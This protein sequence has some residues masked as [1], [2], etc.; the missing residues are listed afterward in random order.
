V[1]K[2][3]SHTRFLVLSHTLP[4]PLTHT[5]LSSQHRLPRCRHSAPKGRLRHRHSGALRHPARSCGTPPAGPTVGTPPP[6][7]QGLALGTR[8]AFRPRTRALRPQP[9][10][11]PRQ[12]PLVG[13]PPR[14]AFKACTRHSPALARALRPPL[15]ALRRQTPLVGTP[16]RPGGLCP[17]ARALARH[18]VRGGHSAPSCRHSARRP[19]LKALRPVG[20]PVASGTPRH[21]APREALR[22]SCG[23]SALRPRVKALRPR[24]A[25]RPQLQAL[26]APAGPQL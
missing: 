17:G 10:A 16:P 4:C 13:T 2:V 18:S 23:H 7:L 1:G 25:L 5:A 24:E 22:P 6:G 8:S 19:H 15:R 20:P 14:G 12:A 3:S 21:S 11:L 26:R 9:R